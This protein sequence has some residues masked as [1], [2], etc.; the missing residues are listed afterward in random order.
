VYEFHGLRLASGMPLG[1]GRTLTAN[2]TSGVMQAAKGMKKSL[3]GPADANPSIRKQLRR[4]IG[5][6]YVAVRAGTTRAGDRDDGV[7]Q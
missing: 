7:G 5:N 2:Y 6:I 1:T 4:P 3:R